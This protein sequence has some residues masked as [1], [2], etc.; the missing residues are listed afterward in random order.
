[1]P[2]DVRTDQKPLVLIH[3]VS[4]THRAWDPVIAHFGD[5]HRII[6]YDLRGH[7]EA[8]K[9]P[10]VGSIDD[11]VDDLVAVLNEAQVTEAHIIGFSLGGLI[12]Q[13]TAI[14]EPE[15]VASL[16]V[17]G[18]VAGRTE[19]EADRARQRLNAIE[20]LG[21]VGVAERSI[22]R[23]FTPQY[24]AAH[25]EA[26]Q[27][28]IT[29][30]AEL[31]RDAYTAAYR[32]LATTDLADDLHQISAPTLAITGEYDIGSP[33]HMSELIAERTGGRAVIVAG[34]KHNIL[35]EQSTRIAKE[36]LAHVNRDEH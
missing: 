12:A 18:A 20:T 32:V 17:I 19:A 31:D 35:Q 5:D 28:V 24:L 9:R 27:E 10:L 2:T 8:P 23:W 34:V 25:P 13:R 11:F 4:D 30:M 22:E 3:G 16:I 21:P 33:P 26:A 29:R 6:R 1:M 14:R 7:G 36:I 15:R